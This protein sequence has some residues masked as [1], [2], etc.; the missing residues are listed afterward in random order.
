MLKNYICFKTLGDPG[1]GYST[2]QNSTENYTTHYG[3]KRKVHNAQAIN[4]ILQKINKEDY[5]KTMSI[6]F[7]S[8][9]KIFYYIKTILFET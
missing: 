7:L 8:L 1:L 3:I 4:F 9:K 2:Y 5:E 6:T